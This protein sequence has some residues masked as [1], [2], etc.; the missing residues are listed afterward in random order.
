MPASAR[1]SSMWVLSRSRDGLIEAG[2]VVHRVVEHS[3]MT[4]QYILDRSAGIRPG[5]GW[6]A[7]WKD[8]RIQGRG[9]E[10]APTGGMLGCAV[11]LGHSAVASCRDD[12]PWDL[13]VRVARRQRVVGRVIV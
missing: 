11:L 12:Q 6:T 8:G 9:A 2:R 4:P 7:L 3:H 5:R 13:A 1:W 10:C